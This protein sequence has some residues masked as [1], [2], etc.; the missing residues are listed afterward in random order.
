M[1][2]TP[3]VAS[4]A[5]CNTPNRPASVARMATVATGGP[6]APQRYIIA[7]K[8]SVYLDPN[9]TPTNIRV[10]Q[11][12]GRPDVDQAALSIARRS[13]YAPRI[14]DCV[15][16]ASV[17]TF[18]AQV[19]A[20]LRAY[21]PLPK[22]EI[23]IIDHFGP[24]NQRVPTHCNGE[25]TV[26][27]AAYPE[28]PNSASR[29]YGPVTALVRVTIGTNGTVLAASIYTSTGSADLDRAALRAARASTYAPKLVNC[30]PVTGTYIFRA[31][32]KPQ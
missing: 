13:R 21:E 12:S 26:T 25:A 15:A 31:E 23:I 7:V 14:I 22:G 4:D 1:I 8:M 3:M 2:L 17:V 10:V 19:P 11:R 28:Y 27:N 29:Q 9:G 24:P 20:Y 30:R 32:F 18:D 5:P 16:K 6:A